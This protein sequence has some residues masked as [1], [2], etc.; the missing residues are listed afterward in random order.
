MPKEWVQQ[1]CLAIFRYSDAQVLFRPPELSLPLLLSMQTPWTVEFGG[2]VQLPAQQASFNVTLAGKT[3]TFD[4]NNPDSVCGIPEASGTTAVVWSI[5]SA[6]LLVTLIGIVMWQRHKASSQGGMFSQWGIST[7]IIHAHNR[8]G[9][10][11]RAANWLWFFVSDVGWTIYSLVTDAI[12]IH[13]VYTSGQVRYAHLLLA[14]LLVPFALR[15]ILI[16]RISIKV[17]QG[18][19]GS[20]TLIRQVA[21]PVVGLL[22]APLFFWQ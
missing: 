4:Y 16:A 9:C 3:N 17:S 7:V 12:M 22:L 2:V 8:L 10:M 6:G 18:K 21:A 14:I 15:F 5:F 1:F 11:K 13:Q 19:I 20:K